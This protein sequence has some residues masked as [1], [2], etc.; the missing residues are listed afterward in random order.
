[1]HPFAK[2]V[3]GGWAAGPPAIDAIVIGVATGNAN[4]GTYTFDYHVM[5]VQ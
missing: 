3:P 4:A 5:E 1:M 2:Y